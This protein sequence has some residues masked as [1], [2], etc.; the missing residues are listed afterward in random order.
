MRSYT[1]SGIVGRPSLATAEKGAVL[2]QALE[3]DLEPHLAELR[4][5]ER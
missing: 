4:R 3:D 2:V 5:Q 1:K